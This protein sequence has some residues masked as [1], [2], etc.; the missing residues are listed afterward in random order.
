M[1][2]RFVL[3]YHQTNHLNSF[4]HYFMNVYQYILN[5]Q[6]FLISDIEINKIE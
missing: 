4:K 3:L 2:N 5:G 1:L 6:L